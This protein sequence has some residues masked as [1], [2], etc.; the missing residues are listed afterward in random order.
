MQWRKR[1]GNGSARRRQRRSQG[2]GGVKLSACSLQLVP[3]SRLT[4]A[5]AAPSQAYMLLETLNWYSQFAFSLD[6][7]Y[8]SALLKLATDDLG[9]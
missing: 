9:V 2:R 7:H 5:G 4:A 1:L 6:V 3:I 8:Q